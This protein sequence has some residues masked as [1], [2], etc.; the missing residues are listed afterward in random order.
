MKNVFS[1]L[2]AIV[3]LGS[4]MISASLPTRADDVSAWGGHYI[5]TALHASTGAPASIVTLDITST[6]ELTGSI[7]PITP[8]APVFTASGKI[9]LIPDAHRSDSK[10]YPF[11]GGVFNSDGSFS[12]VCNGVTITGTLKLD[13]KTGRYKVALPGGPATLTK[14]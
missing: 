14:L 8:S 2:A 11:E 1:T 6:G 3:L 13:S 9:S 12:A 7:S 10:A 5:G 4:V